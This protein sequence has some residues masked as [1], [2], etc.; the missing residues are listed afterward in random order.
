MLRKF[1]RL[2]VLLLACMTCVSFAA[3]QTPQQTGAK[4]LNRL[5]RNGQA[6]QEGRQLYMQNNCAG[7]HGAGGGGGMAPSIIDDD[8]KFGSDDETLFKLIKGQLPQQT[9]PR[10]YS[11]MPEQDVWKI[12]AFIRSQYAGDPS[13]V[14]W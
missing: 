9:M 3:A 12:I 2:A 1:I 10:V 14:N 8:W 6:I 13:K 4:K 5:A 7:C 11:A